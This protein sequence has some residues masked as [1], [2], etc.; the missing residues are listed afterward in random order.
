M[1]DKI[2]EA[3]GLHLCENSICL[4]PR[5]VTSFT[6]SVRPLLCVGLWVFGEVMVSSSYGEFVFEFTTWYYDYDYG[7]NIIIGCL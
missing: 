4:F 6:D 1:I 3:E 7:R 5:Q 2:E